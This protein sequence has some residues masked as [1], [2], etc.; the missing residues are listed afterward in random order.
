MKIKKIILIIIAILIIGI[1]GV[2]LLKTGENKNKDNGKLQIV[3]SN[4]ASY[5]FLRAIIGDSKDIELTFML[6]PGKEAHSYEPT[7]QDLINIQ[8]VELKS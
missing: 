6:G 7:A 4:F 1:M 5:D 2:L 3:A 8:N